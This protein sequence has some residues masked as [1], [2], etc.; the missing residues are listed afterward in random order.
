MDY[1]NLLNRAWY[2]VWR[3][4]FLIILGFLG[5]FS[6]GSGGGAS[7][8]INFRFDADSA[9][10]SEV[11]ADLGIF[12]GLSIPNWLALFLV[13][14]GLLAGVVLWIISTLARGGLIAGAAA[15]DCGQSSSL[16]QAWGA[17]RRRGWTLLGIGLIPAIPVLVIL[18]LGGLGFYVY[19]TNSSTSVGAPV[20]SAAGLI[21]VTLA[22]IAVLAAVGL[23]VLRAL[24][25]RACMLEDLG[26]IDSYLRGGRVLVDN[27]GS[28]LILFVIQVAISIAIG[29]LL[30]VPGAILALCFLFWPV[31]VLFV[32]TVTA[33][34]ST[35]WTLA[36]RRWTRAMPVADRPLI[37]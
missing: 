6:A 5:A 33:Y 21:A 28:A 37:A 22:C 3:H 9:L 36:W 20:R 26:V 8:G 1:G 2:I 27:L 14:F 34:L 25:N 11:F 12:S 13:G 23:E 4:K 24:A 16:S 10:S 18:L 15:A 30:I 7:S 19:T 35:M 29:V 17:G 32:G 31:I